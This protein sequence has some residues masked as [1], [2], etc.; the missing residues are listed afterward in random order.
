MEKP[1]FCWLRI[2]PDGRP[3]HCSSSCALWDEERGQCLVKSIL[4][5][6]LKDERGLRYR[7]IKM[8]DAIRNK[9]HSEEGRMRPRVILV[10][11]PDEL[12]FRRE[13]DRRV[14]EYGVRWVEAFM[15]VQD[16]VFEREKSDYGYTFDW[17]NG[18]LYLLELALEAT[19]PPSV[20]PRMLLDLHFLKNITISKSTFF[21]FLSTE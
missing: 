12:G 2:L 5:K 3:I 4:E 10:G 1:K 18:S 17:I 7:G 16:V 9:P 20:P 15:L 14:D 11:N 21:N 8:V 13:E 6:M 19:A